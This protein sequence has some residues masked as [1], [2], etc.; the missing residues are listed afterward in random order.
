M[1][2]F[3]KRSHSFVR[4]APL[5]IPDDPTL[6][7][8]NAGMN[9]FKSIF[10]N[11]T[12]PTARRVV[13]SQRCMRVSGKHNDLEEVGFSPHHHTL[14]E[15]LGNWS[16]G[17]YYKKEA[18]QWAW[19]LLTNLWSLP[20]EKLWITVFRDEEGE[21]PED[22]DAY[23]FWSAASGLDP[24]RI[25]YFGR[26][27]NFWEMGE[28][29]PCG[30]C[31]EIH[32]D[33]GPEFCD[34]QHVPGHVCRV[35]GDCRRIVEL[36]NLVFIQYNR[37][38]QDQ[39]EDLPKQ[40]VDTGMGLE[41]I[42]AVL[43]N[44]PSNY[45]TDLFIPIMDRVQD[46]SRQT[47]DQ[48][49]RDVISYRVIADHIR[50]ASFLL[51]DGVMPSNEWRGYVLRRIIRRAVR[52]GTK[53]G[54]HDPFL[55]RV[56][57]SFIRIMAPVYSEL[58][59]SSSHISGMLKSEEQRFFKTLEQGL[60]LV[61]ELIETTRK[62]NVKV[63]PG[64]EVFKLYDTYGFPMDITRE[65]AVESG[66]DIDEQGFHSAM[67]T[68]RTRA[69]NAWKTGTEDTENGFWSTLHETL[70]PIAFTGYETL[71]DSASI[72]AIVDSDKTVQSASG[73]DTELYFI[74]N[75]TPF[76]AESGG[77]VGDTGIL[78][79]AKSRIRVL[80]TINMNSGLPVLRAEI[81]EGSVHVGDSAT[82]SVHVFKRKATARNHTATHLLHHALRQVLGEHV[83]QAGS[84]VSPERMRFDFTH[85]T[86]ASE[87]D[88]LEIE[89]RVNE[90]VLADLPVITEIMSLDEALDT[91]VTALFGEK[92]GESVRVV[93]VPG[94]SAELCG[95]THIT[96]T[97][98]IGLF[99]I[100][101]ESGISAG[102]RR[103]EAVTGHESLRK[104]NEWISM[105]QNVSA[106]LKTPQDTVME[107]IEK[108]QKQLRDLMREI[109]QVKENAIKR[110]LETKL[111][112]PETIGGVK[113]VIHAAGSLQINQLRDLADQ[114][115]QRLG[116]CIVLLGS[117][118]DDRV[119]LIAAV[120]PDLTKT[121]HAGKLVGAI[122]GMVGGGG[123]GRPDMA[124]AGGNQPE[125]L[126]EALSRAASLIASTLSGG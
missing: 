122:A 116:S 33:R 111:E 109:G 39:L 42:T 21:I 78:E 19:D 115:K 18:I 114:I 101:S 12:E 46:L 103:I 74:L 71:T 88:I 8:T 80:D 30:P 9:Q 84:L 67:N 125:K 7:F 25:C 40:H 75:P 95:G 37:T 32:I 121:V 91:G 47:D 60:P 81:L 85:F 126:G 90:S 41:R 28:A 23:R 82:A 38:G 11:K 5:F 14:F 64:G 86:A 120:T 96:R 43:Q 89:R 17:D 110:D 108:M 1:D 3:L 100:L 73:N 102:V 113:T 104:C 24:G 6:L 59:D 35:N 106:V 79:T 76:Y 83:K 31:T 107:K 66:L 118:V 77:Q 54:F 62:T 124:Q 4:S 50:A 2:F 61:N 53:L 92:Y 99:K 112:S 10:L 13:N 94:V 70:G 27:D 16:F 65:I 93:R 49:K 123:G 48:R 68:Q 26:K 22:S 69:R 87:Q 63:I 117:V 98:E 29:G 34:K 58:S 105:I 97:G 20:T 36:W 15:M 55:Y 119:F 57:E 52:F 72:L 44:A 51:A 56:A 45:D